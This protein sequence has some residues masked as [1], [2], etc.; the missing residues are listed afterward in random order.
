[1]KRIVMLAPAV[2][3]ALLIGGLAIL[4]SCEEQQ[5]EDAPQAA[6]PAKAS[7][8]ELAG[9][10]AGDSEDLLAALSSNDRDTVLVA[11]SLLTERGDPVG[12]AKAL[13]LLQSD[14]SYVWL[15]AAIYLGRIGEKSAVPYLI[16][17]LDHPAER[18]HGEIA[19]LLESL[20]GEDFGMDQ[21]R[22]IAWWRR[23]NPRSEFEFE[24]PYQIVSAS[25]PSESAAP[26]QLLVNRVVG[27]LTLGHVD[28]LIRLAGVKLK[29][30]ADAQGAER[31]LKS[32]VVNQWVEV[33]IVG[34]TG[35][36]DTAFDAAF[37]YWVAA[38]HP[39]LDR[40][41]RAGLAPVP[42]TDRTL[43]NAYLLNHGPYE[44]DAATVEDSAALAELRAAVE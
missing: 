10:A 11:L 4:M 41:M 27:P 36:S 44:L 7:A 40:M 12:K 34:R 17:G 35:A 24:Y 16:K 2:A 30:G 8:D 14:D 39:E 19:D 1:M 21:S 28:S 18:A 6:A 20:T 42:F 13:D 37:V 38:G 22:W 43:I 3:A 33:R 29:A 32:L 5:G 23:K 26:E 25:A 9:L 15:N 31:L